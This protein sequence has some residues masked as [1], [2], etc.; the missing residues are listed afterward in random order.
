MRKQESQLQMKITKELI[1]ERFEEYNHRYFAGVLGKCKFYFLPKSQPTLGKYNGQ[2]DKNG[3]HI[4]RIGIGTSVIWYEELFKRVLIH[5]MVHMYNTRIDKCRLDGVL[6][7]GRRFRREAKRLKKEFGIDI[8]TRK[9]KVEFI[10]SEFYPKR[11]ETI[12]LWII[13]R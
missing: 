10:N 9:M 12:L 6:G 8:D 11:W 4:D 2:E 1:K 3:K 13:D 5:E 7:H